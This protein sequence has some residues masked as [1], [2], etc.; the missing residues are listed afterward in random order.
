MHRLHASL[1]TLALS[2]AAC[3]PT[4]TAIPSSSAPDATATSTAPP[5]SSVVTPVPSN[6]PATAFLS[7]KPIDIPDP[8]PHVYGGG[9]PYA[10]V[11]FRS[12][13]IAIGTVG[14]ACCADGDPSMNWGI[15]WTSAD[16][17]S[18]TLHDKISALVHASPTGLVT[19]GTRLVAFGGYGAPVPGGQ[20]TSVAAA[21]V[22]TD[23]V[24]WTRAHDPAPTFV[25]VG[26]RG[27]VGAVTTQASDGSQSFRFVS[28]S[29]GLT[30]TDASR[31]LGA[32]LRG[33]AVGPTGDAMAV[34]DA[35]PGSVAMDMLVW[36]SPDG[37][38]WSDP[39]VIAHAATPLSVVWDSGSF[40]VVV[41]LD[42]LLPNG[43]HGD[44]RQVWGLVQGG[45]PQVATIDVGDEGLLSTG[46]FVLGDAIIVSG[47]VSGDPYAEGAVWVST[48][49]GLTFGRVPDQR[50]FAQTDTFING[51]VPTPD[52]LLA[53]GS[54]W[55]GP[56]V[57]PVPEIWLAAR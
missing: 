10:V 39:Q 4:G 30:W 3:G 47:T 35:P 20:A 56:S 6:P 28:S 1:V 38:N 31:T 43:S 34:G 36:R 45:G 33:L 12:S 37:L 40:F 55:D 27:F 24:R 18:W 44:G 51:L 26:P 11:A 13:Y 5:P 54:R 19:D 7:W 41:S 14:A 49:G 22:S 8:A 21:W 16:G 32:E 52:G 23:G 57:H 53:A 46:L 15:V 29:D 50:A 2:V 9:L 25:A 48:D 17:H 42:V